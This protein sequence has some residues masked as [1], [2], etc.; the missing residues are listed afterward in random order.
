MKE[1]YVS[2]MQNDKIYKVLAENLEDAI[3]QIKHY[4]SH[5]YDLYANDETE[6]YGWWDVNRLYHEISFA[7]IGFGETINDLTNYKF[8]YPQQ[9]CET[10]ERKNY[11]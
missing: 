5:I 2:F 9:F 3:K 8:T 7:N 4:E 6:D 10:F 11:V 1:M